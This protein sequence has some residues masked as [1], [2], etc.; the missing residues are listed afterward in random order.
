[1]ENSMEL[2]RVKFPKI[3]SVFKR[4]MENG[5]D[6]NKFI[7]EDWTTPEFE[8]LKN[9]KWEATE[10]LDGTN[11]RVIWTGEKVLF[12]GR[13]HDS[14]LPADLVNYLIDTY[15]KEKFLQ[16]NLPP[17]ILFGE[18]IGKG[19]QKCGDKYQVDSRYNKDFILFD[20]FIDGF[21]LE[22][23][24]VVDIAFKLPGTSIAQGLSSTTLYQAIE[25]VEK[26]FN[27]YHG[28]LK[29][30]GFVLR[31]PC[32]MLDRQGNRIITKVKTRD[33]AKGVVSK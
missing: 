5:P 17:L 21:W 18:G 10:K 13:D 8:A 33:F 4:C 23:A 6:K 31:A 22:R 20:V 15:P 30:E 9:L 19:I 3:Q 14:A 11:T 29:A 12:G 27:S 28:N 26:G 24:N 2:T 32:G 25:N 7:W 1:M 16:A